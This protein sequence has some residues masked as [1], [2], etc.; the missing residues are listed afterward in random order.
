MPRRLHTLVRAAHLI[1]PPSPYFVWITAPAI[2]HIDTDPPAYAHLSITFCLQPIHPHHPNTAGEVSS[3]AGE[4]QRK[5]RPLVAAQGMSSRCAAAPSGTP[6]PRGT[7]A[8][9]MRPM[10]VHAAA[11]ALTT[12]AG[13]RI[14]RAD[15]SPSP[16][17]GPAAP[18]PHLRTPPRRW[19][20]GSS[21]FPHAPWASGRRARGLSP[22]CSA[23]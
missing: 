20:P 21:A 1:C 3:A 14:S 19:P 17:S 13:V 4:L 8:L 9:S 22:P 10:P 23:S 7:T 12:A 5:P 18:A 6:P 15:A 11:N 16:P 2:R